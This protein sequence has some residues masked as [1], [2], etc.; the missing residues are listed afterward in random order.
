MGRK[1][2]QEEFIA[3]LKEKNPNVYTTD[4]YINAIT[5]ITFHCKKNKEH[6]WMADPHHILNGRGC[7]FCAR[8]KCGQGRVKKHIQQNPEALLCDHNPELIPYLKDKNDAQKY[9]YASGK[10]VEWICPDCIQSFYKV[11]SQM[12]RRGFRCPICARN[13]SYPN[14]FIISL[15]QQ[16]GIH[17]KREYS[18]EWISPKRYDFYFEQNNKKYIV[19]MDGYFHQFD[20]YKQVDKYKDVMAQKHGITMIRIDCIYKSVEERFD[21]IR[22]HILN[23][24]LSDLFDLSIIDFQRCDYEAQEKTYKQICA[25]WEEVH[26]V[27]NIC[28]QLELSDTTVIKYLK[29]GEK[30]QLCSYN[31]E[32]ETKKN[33]NK[34]CSITKRKLGQAVRCNETGEVFYSMAD[35]SRHYHCAVGEYFRFKRSYSGI[36]PDGTKLT[37]TKIAS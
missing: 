13:Y 25:L 2:T 30:Y 3:E 11:I 4:T 17:F 35:A 36:L 8:E 10:S 21:Y 5:K 37:W 1:K 28:E 27:K 33:L 15:F 26:S 14:K 31:H 18:P 16:L 34:G 32:E 6:I 22:Q 7:P 29:F 24:I 20:N 19:E 9:T 23:S 12:T